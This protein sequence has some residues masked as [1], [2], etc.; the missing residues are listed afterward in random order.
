MVISWI[1]N[2]LDDCEDPRAFGKALKGNLK[3]KW[4]YR[5]GEYRLICLIKDEELLILALNTGHRRDI[6]EE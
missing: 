4:S 2:H 3:G 5:I 1:E 6:Y